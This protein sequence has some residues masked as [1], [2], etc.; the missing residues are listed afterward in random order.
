MVGWHHRINGHEFEQA[1]E[2]SERQGSL[3][4]CIHG[5]AKSQTRLSHCTITI[6]KITGTSYG[7]FKMCLQILS[8]LFL[9]KAEPNSFPLNVHETQ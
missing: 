5:V 2:D 7:S 4:C 9:P 3:A 8:C 6:A 1:S